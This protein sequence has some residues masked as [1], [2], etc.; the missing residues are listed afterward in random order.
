MRRAAAAVAAGLAAAAAPAQEAPPAPAPAAASAAEQVA[1]E[2]V[3]VPFLT[4][5]QEALF[6]RSAFG[7]RMQAELEAA[8]AALAAENRRI[9]TELAE[10]ERR[11]TALRGT[12]DPAEFRALA[13]DFDARVVA[14]RRTQ[15]AKTRDLA[16]RPD[17]ARA[18]FLRA[19]LP[20]LAQIARDRGAVAILDARAVLISAEAID[21]T[22]EAIA[23][24]DTAIG[25]G[26][27][28]LPPPPAPEP[29]DGGTAA[30]P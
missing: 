20:V 24:L 11:L 19:A 12:M 3:V 13:D 8:T 21:I 29:A 15:D 7:R 18:V 22:D 17:E 26:E 5:D 23:Q 14:L 16:R 4:I 2:Q 28:L 9:E 10:E 25:D 6:A 1:A 27:A 30:R